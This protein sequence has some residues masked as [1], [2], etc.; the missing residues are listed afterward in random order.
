MVF[1]VSASVFSPI[2]VI[3]GVCFRYY[4]YFQI[5]QVFSD[6]TGII[7]IAGNKDSED[8]TM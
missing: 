7:E 3:I 5:L 6:I 1:S 4:R 2:T 8:Y